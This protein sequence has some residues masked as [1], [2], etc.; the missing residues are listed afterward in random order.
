MPRRHYTRELLAP[1]V[2]NSRSVAGVLRALELR[3]AGVTQAHVAKRIRQ[4]GIDTSHFLGSRTNSGPGHLPVRKPA[5]ELLVKKP[6]LAARTHANK[7]RRAL[8][9][10]GRE[11]RCEGCGLDCWRDMPITL[12]IDHINGEHNDNRRDNLRFLCPNCH[13]QTETYC[14]KNLRVGEQ[15]AVYISD[16]EAA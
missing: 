7:L 1:V 6:E 12:E 2:A 15:L 11:L 4:L 14:V 10:I 16:R 3:Q 8:V 5:A 13:S 9:E